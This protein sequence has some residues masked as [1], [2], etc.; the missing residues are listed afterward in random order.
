MEN[1]ILQKLCDAFGGD[2]KIFMFALIFAF[3]TFAATSGTGYAVN[4]KMEPTNIKRPLKKIND[5]VTGSVPSEIVLPKAIKEPDI[6][7]A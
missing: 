2:Y 4:D 6:I 7:Q 5:I 3:A 1:E